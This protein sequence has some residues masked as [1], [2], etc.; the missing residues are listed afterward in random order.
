[1]LEI[2]KG[3]FTGTQSGWGIYD[4]E[5]EQFYSQEGIGRVICYEIFPQLQPGKKYNIKISAKVVEV[6]DDKDDRY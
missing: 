4:T 3:K 5:S 1:M 6:E 2:K